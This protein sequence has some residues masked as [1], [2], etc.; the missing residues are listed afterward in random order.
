MFADDM[1]LLSNSSENLQRMVEEVEA[2]CESKH[3]KINGTKS[4]YIIFGKVVSTQSI[5]IA[6]VE[7]NNVAMIK[8]LGCCISHKLSNHEHLFDRHQKSRMAMY[9]LNALGVKSQGMA[10][11]TKM[12]IYKIYCKPI[13]QYGWET[14]VINK[15]MI[16]KEQRYQNCCVKTLIGLNWRTK[17]TDLMVAL[18]IDSVETSILKNKITFLQNLLKNGFTGKML[19]EYEKEINEKGVKLELIGNG[20]WI[21]NLIKIVGLDKF[22]PVEIIKKLSSKIENIREGE[23]KVKKLPIFKTIQGCLDYFTQVNKILLSN[24]IK[25]NF[26][27]G[28]T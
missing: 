1:L 15:T 2:F 16:E 9:E 11:R 26:S 24:I 17:S 21:V 20:S 23:R 4:Q 22:N 8:Y 12:L 5:N 10:V 18:G 13:I 19:A 27:Y 7:I 14:M 28:I 25:I 3:I 6:G